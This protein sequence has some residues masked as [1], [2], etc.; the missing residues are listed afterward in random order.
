[1]K[2]A[3]MIFGEIWGLFVDDGTLA[4]LILLWCA[5]AALSFGYLNISEDMRGPLFLAGLVLGLLEN[6]WRKSRSFR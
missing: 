2:I 6:V 5:I 1:M 4:V 3:S